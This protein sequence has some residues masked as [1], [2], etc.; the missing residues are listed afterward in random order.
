MYLCLDQ[1]L[2]RD[3]F[4]DGNWYNLL[5][6]DLNN[7][8]NLHYL[9]NLNNL[10]NLHYLQNLNYLFHLNYLLYFHYFLN[11]DNLFNLYYL[12]HFH[13]LFYFNYFFNLHYLLC[14]DFNRHDAIYFLNMTNWNLNILYP[15]L[16]QLNGHL[17]KPDDLDQLFHNHLFDN[18][19]FNVFDLLLNNYH[20][21]RY[22]YK[23][24]NLLITTV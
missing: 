5:Y 6:L 8:L 17:H 20:L 7:L 1:H 4:N 13:Y 22:L 18:R 9:Q 15:L 12:L 2:D 24:L 3:L 19:N 11:L 10:L 14:F 16:N 21:S 23:F